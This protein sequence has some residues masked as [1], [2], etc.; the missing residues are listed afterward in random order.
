M[1]W[2]AVGVKPEDQTQI[3]KNWGGT[4]MFAQIKQHGN[5]FRKDKELAQQVLHDSTLSDERARFKSLDCVH[6][7]FKNLEKDS[8]RASGM[9]PTLRTAYLKLICIA[10]EHGEG[11]QALNWRGEYIGKWDEVATR[12]N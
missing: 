6:K 4:T 7:I 10:L 8:K 3:A 9:R 5:E 11:N 1:Q 12:V 2:T